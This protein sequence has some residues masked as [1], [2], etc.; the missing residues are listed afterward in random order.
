MICLYKILVIDYMRNLLLM[1]VL[2][3]VYYPPSRKKNRWIFQICF[4]GAPYFASGGNIPLI[5]VFCSCRIAFL[6]P[7]PTP[8]LLLLSYKVSGNFDFPLFA[9][10]RPSRSGPAETCVLIP[11]RQ[12]NLMIVEKLDQK[13]IKND[14]T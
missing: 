14:N 11:K 4:T 7:R 10:F 5:F 3:L 2:F 6:T 13:I 8:G 12:R 9:I 1:L